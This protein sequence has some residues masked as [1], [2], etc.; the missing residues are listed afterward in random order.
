MA[1]F[2]DVNRDTTA[3]G[4]AECLYRILELLTAG[5]KGFRLATVKE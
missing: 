2:S 3:N 5:T 1:I 4:A